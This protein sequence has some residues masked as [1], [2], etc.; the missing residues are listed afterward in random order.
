MTDEVCDQ[1][2]AWPAVIFVI[3]SLIVLAGIALSPYFNSDIRAWTF[4]ILLVFAIVWTIIIYWFCHLG[5]QTIGWFMLTLPI[6]VYFAWIVSYWM[7]TA[8]TYD[9]CVMGGVKEFWPKLLNS[10]GLVK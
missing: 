1:S 5:Y 8:T 2:T 9:E 6:F 7:A 10:V 4:V 3:L